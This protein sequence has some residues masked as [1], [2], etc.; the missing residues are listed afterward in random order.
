MK[1]TYD[2]N[3]EKCGS[4]QLELKMSEVPIS[5]CPVC[6]CERIIRIFPATNTVWKCDG[7]Y[8]KKNHKS[9]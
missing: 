6:N 7:A 8:S 4:V 3:C 5:K 1:G 9:E 2:Y